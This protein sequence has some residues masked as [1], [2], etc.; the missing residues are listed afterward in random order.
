MDMKKLEAVKNLVAFLITIPIWF[1]LLHSILVA[2]NA[3]DL[4]FFLF[5]VYVP[6]A[7]FVHMVKE[8][9]NDK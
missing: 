9:L 6:F 4:Q 5:W 8:Y 2:I 1:Y 7:T 3:T